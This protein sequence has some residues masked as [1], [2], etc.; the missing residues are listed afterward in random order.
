MIY[1]DIALTPPNKHL[2]IFL[3]THILGLK[4]TGSRQSS[5]VSPR[6]MHGQAKI[7][8]CQWIIGVCFF[9]IKNIFDASITFS[10]KYNYCNVK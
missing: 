1:T 2:E 6:L 8:N 4:T 3:G 7:D 9:R 5:G 10:K